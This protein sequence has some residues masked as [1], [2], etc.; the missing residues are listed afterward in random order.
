M[1]TV[2]IRKNF[3]TFDL[4]CTFA[5]PA[6]GITALY[7]ASGAGKTSIVRAIAGALTPD[8]GRIAVGDRVL[9]D[10]ATGID[11]PA[12]AR[13]IGY[14]FQESRLF[15]HLSVRANLLYGYKRATGSKRHTL[16]AIVALLDIAPLLDRRIHNLS[17][18]ERQRVAIG[19]ALLAQP[20]MLLMD[21][22]LASLDTKRKAELLPYIESL[23]DDPGLPIIYI[24]HAFDEVLR[25]ADHLVIVDGGRTVREGSL[26]D[27]SIDPA[28][29]PYLDHYDAGTVIVCRIDHQTP[30]EGLTG[31]VFAGGTLFVPRVDLAADAQV[32]V[33]FPARDV[34]IALS[35]PVD[36]SITNRLPGRIVAMHEVDQTY[37][38]VIVDVGGVRLRARIMRASVA[39]LKLSVGQSVWALI[40]SVAFDSRSVGGA[41]T[42]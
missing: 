15:P 25:L 18:G 27:L 7:G 35:D 3:E 28:V 41:R 32:R 29:T 36:S 12:H 21:E 39:R 11:L 24:S 33:R 9:F 13:R 42:R 34:S 2:A 14:V 1:L 30:A 5:A 37:S 23:R 22:P 8:A 6:A 38:D 26:F 17:G 20:T 16:D 4:D 10:A 40:K 31:L 19:R